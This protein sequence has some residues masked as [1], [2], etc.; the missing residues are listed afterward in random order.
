MFLKELPHLYK[1]KLVFF[2][3]FQS[4]N[5]LKLTIELI[6]LAAIVI[7]FSALKINFMII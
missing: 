4:R 6:T 3:N 5:K 7:V 1:L 2:K